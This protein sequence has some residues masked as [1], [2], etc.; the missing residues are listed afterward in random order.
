MVDTYTD[1]DVSAFTG[2]RRPQYERLLADITPAA[3][4]RYWCGIR[5][6]LTV[7]HSSWKKRS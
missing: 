1:N 6:G 3:S 5:I 7:P 4:M 2:R